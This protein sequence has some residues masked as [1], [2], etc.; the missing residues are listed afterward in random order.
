MFDDFDELFNRFFSDKGDKNES[1]EA[2]R[3]RR[4]I[5]RLNNFDD[6]NLEGFNPYENDLGEPD[7]VETYEEKGYTFQRSTWNLESGSIVKVEMV[8]L[9]TDG[10]F[11]P[12]V[13]KKL[14]LQEKLEIALEC[15]DY[16]EAIKLRDEINQ[17]KV[18]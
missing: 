2:K 13:N 4:L 1:D 8:S 5:D 17:K 16:E 6:M 15:E 3:T 18:K 7:E 9:P 14:T 11:E 10:E 12:K